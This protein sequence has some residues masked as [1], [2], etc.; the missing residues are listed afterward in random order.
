MKTILKAF[1]DDEYG[2]AVIDWAVL[3]IGVMMLMLAIALSFVVP[4]DAVANGLPTP[5]QLLDA[6]G[7]KV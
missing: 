2:N 6:D 1:A 7:T 4:G 5:E 3:S